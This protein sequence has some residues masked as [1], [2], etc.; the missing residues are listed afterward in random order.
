MHFAEE[1]SAR[2]NLDR[3][4]A[5]GFVLSGFF[6]LRRIGA[7]MMHTG[8]KG[9]ML[10]RKKRPPTIASRIPSRHREPRGALERA[11]GAVR[12]NSVAFG[13]AAQWL[14]PCFTFFMESAFSPESK[15]FVQPK[16]GT[17]FCPFD[18][19]RRP[20]RSLSRSRRDRLLK[21][22]MNVKKLARRNGLVYHR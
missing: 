15:A 20:S 13:A 16:A 7:R 10:H 11:P 21:Y 19:P 5:I 9:R 22:V 1:N 14:S 4:P 18:F 6:S 2:F 3:E 17:L 8:A 12:S